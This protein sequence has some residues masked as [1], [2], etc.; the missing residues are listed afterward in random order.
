MSPICLV[1]EALKLYLSFLPFLSFDF[2]VGRKK[3][4]PDL[5]DLSVELRAGGTW[6]LHRACKVSVLQNDAVREPRTYCLLLE[7][8]VESTAGTA[9]VVVVVLTLTL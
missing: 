2:C 3:F 6:E 1:Y 5:I 9:V 7:T 4:R 8:A